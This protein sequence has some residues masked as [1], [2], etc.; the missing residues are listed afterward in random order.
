MSI[1]GTMLDI[2]VLWCKYHWIIASVM[3]QD[4]CELLLIV[5]TGNDEIQF[6][7]DQFL[8]FCFVAALLD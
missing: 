2:Q 3:Y 1:I 8:E 4:S 5:V 7:V 6:L